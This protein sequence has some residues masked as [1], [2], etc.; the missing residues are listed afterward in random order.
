MGTIKVVLPDDLEEKLRNHI[1]I[2]KGLRKGVLSDS[3]CEAI[4][5]WLKSPN[6][7]TEHPDKFREQYPG[8]FLAISSSKVLFES[9]TLEELFMDVS[10][11]SEKVYI[12]HPE[13]KKR[14]IRLGWRSQ[15]KS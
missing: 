3:V 2:K 7:E 10:L 4:N 14:K 15:V 5:L 9:D 12:I 13:L 8:K 6:G 1:A 11:I